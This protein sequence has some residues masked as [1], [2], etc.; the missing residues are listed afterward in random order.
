MKLENNYNIIIL[1]YRNVS[2]IE[3]KKTPEK[4]KHRSQS[5]HK[6]KNFNNVFNHN[7]DRLFLQPSSNNIHSSHNQHDSTFSTE[8][9]NYRKSYRNVES[10]DQPKNQAYMPYNFINHPHISKSK[11]LPSNKNFL[12]QKTFENLNH[13]NSHNT[14]RNPQKP[15]TNFFENHLEL[16]NPEQTN[17]T[18]S[19]DYNVKTSMSSIVSTPQCSWFVMYRGNRQS[20]VCLGKCPC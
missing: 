7:Y 3:H 17:K 13:I 4:E 10:V 2:K 19:Q 16:T 11:L 15:Q 8:T 12:T 6:A 20:L 9:N 14:N 1:F 18:K 5:E